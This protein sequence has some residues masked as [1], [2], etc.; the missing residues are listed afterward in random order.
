MKWDAIWRP[1]SGAEMSYQTLY[2]D[3]KRLG[4]IHGW[5]SDGDYGYDA[6]E[7]INET[8]IGT[9]KTRAEAQAAVEA[10]VK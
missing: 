1:Y 5:A 8:Y 7:L 9:F 2:E 10:A 6:Y 4:K 3:D